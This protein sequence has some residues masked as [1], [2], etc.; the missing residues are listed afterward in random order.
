[1]TNEAIETQEEGMSRRDFF[2]NSALAVGAAA[3]ISSGIPQTLANG[4]EVF[5]AFAPEDAAAAKNGAHKSTKGSYKSKML[6]IGDSRT[7]EM[8]DLFDKSKDKTN[9]ASYCSTWG[10]HYV[11]MWPSIIYDEY[12][13]QMK[14]HIQYQIKNNG[15]CTVFVVGTVNDDPNTKNAKNCVALAK[16]LNSWAKAQYKAKKLKARPVFYVMGTC[17][18][19]N[20]KNG[21]DGYN[22]AL[23]AAVKDYNSNYVKYGTTKDCVKGFDDNYHYNDATYKAIMKKFKK[24]AQ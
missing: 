10:G 9:R 21:W 15:K 18:T 3:L 17:G 5:S 6:V 7:Y 2:R 20:N 16:E 1:M 8:W 11:K 4:S 12:K 13:D 23:K 19:R 22:T 24:I 14:S